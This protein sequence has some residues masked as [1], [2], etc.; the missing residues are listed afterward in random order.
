MT[1]KAGF[2]FDNFGGNIDVVIVES[3][4]ASLNSSDCVLSIE[5]EGSFKRRQGHHWS[6]WNPGS[7][8]YSYRLEFLARKISREFSI[9]SIFFSYGDASGWMQYTLFD[10]GTIVEEYS[11]GINYD[12]DMLEAGM[13]PH[14]DLKEATVVSANEDEKF[15]F[16]SSVRSKSDS[17]ICG[18]E[19]FIDEFLRSHNAYI[20]WDLFEA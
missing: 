7:S 5:S 18:G 14:Q 11:F 3:N 2:D 6:A 13:D 12:D 9:K 17:E 15:I 20:G 10:Q 8:G 4:P 16:W 19:T 1:D